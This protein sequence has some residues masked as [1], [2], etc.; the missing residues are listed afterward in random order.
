MFADDLALTEE[1]ELKVRRAI[2]EWKVA[3]ESTGLKVNMEKTKLLVTGKDSIYK[4]QSG[5]WPCGCCGKQVGVNSILCIQ[6]NLRCSGLKRVS[7]GTRFSVPILQG[8]E[9]Y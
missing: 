8:K 9:E 5:R 1:S 2:E 6:C 4:V 3:M 7:W